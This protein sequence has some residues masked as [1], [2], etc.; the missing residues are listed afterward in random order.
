MNNLPDLEI[1][2]DPHDVAKFM[3]LIAWKYDVDAEELVS[4]WQDKQA[5]MVWRMLAKELE[6]CAARCDKIV[7]KHFG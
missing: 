1:T 5:G 6:K 7:E 2:N 3:R 4:A